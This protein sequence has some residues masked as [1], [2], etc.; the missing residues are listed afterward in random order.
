MDE[1]LPFSNRSKNPFASPGSLPEGEGI[2]DQLASLG[3]KTADIEYCI[4][5]HMGILRVSHG[6][7][8]RRSSP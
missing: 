8:S 3:Y 6:I 1:A 5:T 4:M 2:I 7:R